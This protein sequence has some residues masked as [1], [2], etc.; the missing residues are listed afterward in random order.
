MCCARKGNAVGDNVRTVALDRLNVRGLHLSATTSVDAQGRTLPTAPTV[1]GPNEKKAVKA[2]G[3]N[4]TAYR[5]DVANYEEFD[6]A[7]KQF[8]EKH[9]GIDI[10]I[11]NVSDKDLAR[12]LFS[13]D[14]LDKRFAAIDK[15]G[16]TLVGDVNPR[17][18][19]ES[20]G[21]FTPVPG[22]V[23]LLTVAMLMKNT[24]KAAKMRRSE[25]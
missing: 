19:I 4:P 20:A 5:F 18:A 24:V 13:A 1:N 11:N 12:E 16:F 21:A 3:G 10:G 2:S 22:G 17:D 8:I 14:D 23:G 6:S 9:H 15:R 7:V 25:R